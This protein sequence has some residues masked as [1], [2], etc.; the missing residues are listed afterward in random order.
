VNIKYNL[1][2]DY[3][4]NVAEAG[5]NIFSKASVSAWL[6]RRKDI[7]RYEFID[8]R[9][10][11]DLEPQDDPVRS[12]T[13]AD[14]TGNRLITNGLSIIQPHGILHIEKAP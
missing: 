8:F 12:W 11:V 6:D 5:W 10:G 13:I 7:A 3:G 2:S 14:S 4:R 9:I 1:S